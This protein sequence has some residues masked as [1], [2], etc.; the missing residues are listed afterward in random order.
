MADT[1]GGN[2]KM[3]GSAS[4]PHSGGNGKPETSLFPLGLASCQKIAEGICG[5]Y[6][7]DE[8]HDPEAFAAALALVLSSYPADIARL[9]GDPR[10]GIVAAFP[11]GLPN[12]GQIKQFLDTALM[13]RER[14]ARLGALPKPEPRRL[15]PPPAGPGARA[16]CLIRSEHPHFSDFLERAKAPGADPRDFRIV[17]EGVWVALAWLPT[18]AAPSA[19]RQ[20]AVPTDE[21][22]ARI[23]ARSKRPQEG[24]S[25]GYDFQ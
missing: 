10:A 14:F 8:A 3:S 25:D 9:A 15:P 1:A 20:F 17:P 4:A 5:C 16:K 22:L 12:V 21:E 19:A 18:H 7:R 6:R 23:Y 2:S 11:L 24:E 13:R